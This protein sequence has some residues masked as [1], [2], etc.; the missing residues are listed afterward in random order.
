MNIAI[1]DDD[2]E[3][4]SILKQDVSRV[5]MKLEEYI[6][7]SMFD[8]GID[9]IASIDNQ[10]KHFDIILLDVDMPGMSGLEVAKKIRKTNE[11]IIIIFVSSHEQYVFDSIEYNP[12][13]YIRK[14]R[15]QEELSIALKSAYTLYKKR[16]KRF[17]IIKSDDGEYRVEQSEICYFE[18]IKRK[19]FVHLTDNR[20]LSMWKSIK[21]FNGEIDSSDF[22]KIHSGCVVNMKYIKEYTNSDVILDN[23]ERLSTSRAGIKL[24]KEELTR[25]WGENI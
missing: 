16:Q 4:K 2:L 20:I 13:R 7:I 8:N 22:V 10:K 17:I 12:F 25:Y 14:N 11:D 5:F 1:C 18:I 23:G 21:D 15:I 24:L 19:L 6:D 9:L 3:I